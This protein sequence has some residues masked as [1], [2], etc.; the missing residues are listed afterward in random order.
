ML[1]FAAIIAAAG[2]LAAAPASAEEGYWLS[3]EADDGTKAGLV[4][5]D[6]QPNNFSVF[7]MVCPQ[8]DGPAALIVEFPIDDLRE[9]TEV[10]VQF[11][12][13]AESVEMSGRGKRDEF[14]GSLV[15]EVSVDRDDA[16]FDRLAKAT[17]IVIKA[18]QIE[19]TTPV[20]GAWSAVNNFTNLC[21]AR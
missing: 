4:F 8:D 19:F 17:S 14:Q 21:R 2:L 11:I 15:I 10:P 20:K 18:G 13:D 9:G 7:W 16:F 12:V 6:Y 1:R 5:P 3:L